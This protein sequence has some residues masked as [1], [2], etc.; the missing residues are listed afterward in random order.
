MPTKMRQNAITFIFSNFHIFL[1]SLKASKC[2][3]LRDKIYET[4]IDLSLIGSGLTLSGS[5]IHCQKKYNHLLCN[6]LGLCHHQMEAVLC[7]ASILFN[8]TT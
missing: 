8:V 1:L 7:L 3:Y 4:H 5:W 2:Q 6:Y